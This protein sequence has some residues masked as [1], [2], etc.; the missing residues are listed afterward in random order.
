M[1]AR[2]T[3]LVVEGPLDS[4]VVARLLK[5]RGFVRIQSK[6]DLPSALA[7]EDLIPER[8][9]IRGNLIARHPVPAFLVRRPCESAVVIVTSGGGSKVQGAVEATRDTLRVHR[10]IFDGV[11]I[12]VDADD[13][14][15]LDLHA[16]F[17]KAWDLASTGSEGLPALPHEAGLVHC[18]GRRRAGVFISPDNRRPGTL[19]TL[20]EEAAGAAYAEQWTYA[21]AYVRDWP[22]TGLTRADQE[23][24]QKPAGAAKASLHALACLLKPGKAIQNSIADNRWFTGATLHLPGVS[25]LVRFL[26]DLVG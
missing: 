7:L 23:E 14:K 25:G 24:I 19:E 12:L 22:R 1:I 15:P 21:R 3:L 5:E 9:P 2:K 26:G 18:E 13:Q 16:Q 20:L 11:G 6:D 4:A 8:F 17:L 10:Q